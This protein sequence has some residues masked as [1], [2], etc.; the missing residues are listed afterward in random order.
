MIEVWR[1]IKIIHFREE[2]KSVC[3]AI[4]ALC[5]AIRATLA[6]EELSLQSRFPR[7]RS[8]RLLIAKSSKISGP[9]IA[10]TNKI[11]ITITCSDVRTRL[12]FGLLW[13][14]QI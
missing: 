13:D 10:N 4:L 3:I 1:V 14:K 6:S 5:I 8:D 11:P 7:P 2:S 12:V 9:K